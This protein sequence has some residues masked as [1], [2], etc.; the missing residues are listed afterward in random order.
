MIIEWVINNVCFKGVCGRGGI[1]DE[2]EIERMRE[3]WKNYEEIS[4]REW[5][6]CIKL[7]VYGN[8]YMILR[9]G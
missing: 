5:R 7:D 8:Y 1:G 6:G 9:R 2:R 3:W 4:K